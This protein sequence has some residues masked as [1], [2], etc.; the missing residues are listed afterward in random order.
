MSPLETQ[1]REHH[2][3]LRRRLDSI[4][5]IHRASD[6]LE[7]PDRRARAVARGARGAARRDCKRQV[8]AID[9]HHRGPRRAAAGGERLTRFVALRPSRAIS[10]SYLSCSS[11]RRLDAIGID[12]NAVD[13]ADLAALRR[14][15]MA[16]AFGAFRRVDHVDLRALRDRLIRAFGLAD[17][18]VDAFVGDDQR[19]RAIRILLGP[20]AMVASTRFA[21]QAFGDERVDELRDVAAETA[22]SRARS[23]P[24]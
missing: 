23:S 12:R 14:V 3:Q 7:E 1:V 4:Q 10:P 15:E 9:T 21:A 8:G 22:R 19:H 2:L 16:D 24:R 18:A 6:E 17:V 13:R 11:A 5:R 20:A